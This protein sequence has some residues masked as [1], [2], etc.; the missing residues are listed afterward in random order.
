[1]MKVN[2]PGEAISGKH[3]PK[4]ETFIH[5]IMMPSSAPGKGDLILI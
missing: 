3:S 4:I 1:M 5:C 2:L